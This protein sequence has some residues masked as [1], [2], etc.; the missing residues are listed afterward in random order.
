[1]LPQIVYPMAGLGDRFLKAG[2]SVPKPLINI[3]GKTMIE[4]AVRSLDAPQECKHVFVV[5][6]YENDSY[7]DLLR[8]TLENL[9]P[10]IEIISIDYVTDGAATTVSLAAPHLDMSAPLIVSDCDRIFTKSWDFAEWSDFIASEKLD[11]CPITYTTDTPKN[12][13]VLTNYSGYIVEVAEK[14]VISNQ[15]TNGVHYWR[16]A[17][18][19][20]ESY[21]SMCKDKSFKSPEKF[22]TPTLQY[23]I[24]KGAKGK[25]Y[26]L[27]DG[28]HLAVGVP[29]DLHEFMNSKGGTPDVDW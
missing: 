29:S 6:K 15:S 12:S 21:D 1:M 10:N 20:F 17:Q 4:L 27:A 16:T 2:F 3:H 14:K 8:D 19:F 26:H 23:L 11:F 24:N 25:P 7:N 5:R 13:Y 28:V 18:S 9:V 22:I